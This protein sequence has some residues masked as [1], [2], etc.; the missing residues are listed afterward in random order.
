MLHPFIATHEDVRERF[1]GEGYVA[2]QV[3]HPG[4]VSVLDDDL[5][6]DGAPFLVMELLDG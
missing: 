6:P 1:L 5:T 3:D 2:N 4:A